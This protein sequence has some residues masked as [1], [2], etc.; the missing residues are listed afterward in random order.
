MD[1][2]HPKK[3]PAMGKQVG[4]D[5]R[6]GCGEVLVDHFGMSKPDVRMKGSR[7]LLLYAVIIQLGEAPPSRGR[8]AGSSPVHR[9][10][11]NGSKTND[12]K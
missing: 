5:W 3:N 6:R 9:S 4:C 12:G 1:C 2:V 10:K 8:V 7:C 11:V